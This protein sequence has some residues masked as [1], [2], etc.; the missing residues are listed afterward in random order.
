MRKDRLELYTLPDYRPRKHSGNNY[1]FDPEEQ[2]TKTYTGMGMDINVHDQWAV[3]SLGKIQDRTQEHLGT[4]DKV[5]IANRKLMIKAI[6]AVKSGGPPDISLRPADPAL[7]R[8]PVAIDTI[9]PAATW[10]DDW[11]KTAAERRSRS[12]WA[13]EASPDAQSAGSLEN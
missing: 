6:E 7:C 5:I 8:G 2:K 3:E 11:K 10:R 13:K 12:S 4:T 9:S 1:G